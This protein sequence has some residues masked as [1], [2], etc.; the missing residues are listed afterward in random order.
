MRHDDQ[1]E[2]LLRQWGA[3]QNGRIAWAA[4]NDDREAPDVHPIARSIPF[5]PKTR[6]RAALKLAGRDGG[7]RLKLMAIRAGGTKVGL[8]KLPTWAADPIRCKETRLSG[9]VAA[10]DAGIPPQLLRVHQAMLDLYRRDPKRGLCLRLEYTLPGPHIEKAE[11][12][13]EAIGEPVNVRAYRVEL[14]MARE[15]MA[16]KLAA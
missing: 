11:R 4:G 14:K 5:A 8:R 10:I 9:P 13:S 6:H 2:E 15:W 7:S 16:A 3:A 1:L 12:V